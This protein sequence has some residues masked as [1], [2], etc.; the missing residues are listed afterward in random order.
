MAWEER[1]PQLNSLCPDRRPSLVYPRPRS[2]GTI[3]GFLKGLVSWNEYFLMVLKLK[4]I[5]F[6]EC[7]IWW[8]F[9]QFLAVFLS[10]KSKIKFLLASMKSLTNCENPSSNP[11]QGACSGFP[12]AAYDYCYV[13]VVPKAGCDPT[14]FSERR[15]WM[16]SGENQPMRAKET[17]NRNMMR[18]SE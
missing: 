13:K 5:V 9:L 10:W 16:Y 4:T 18:L 6:N 7:W 2:P 8:F 17:R 14:F 11:R 15:P 3:H 12:R 1:E